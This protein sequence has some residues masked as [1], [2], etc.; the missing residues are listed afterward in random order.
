[1]EQ[2]NLKQDTEM[3]KLDTLVFISEANKI[4]KL[5]Y[6]FRFQ[7]KNKKIMHNLKG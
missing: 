7:K 2:R 4:F 5:K 3:I 6:K 1:M